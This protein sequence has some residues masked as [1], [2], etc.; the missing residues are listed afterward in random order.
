MQMPFYR[1]SRGVASQ[2]VEVA[3]REMIRQP[4][5]GRLAG[6]PCIDNVSSPHAVAQRTNGSGP[7]LRGQFD[8]PA[9]TVR[10]PT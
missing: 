10:G 6:P 5:L 9:G 2:N 7:A 4:V 3:A 1:G 8:V